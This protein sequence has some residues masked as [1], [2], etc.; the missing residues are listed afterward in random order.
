ML[1][2]AGDPVGRYRVVGS[3][4]ANQT[5]YAGMVTVERT[6]ETFRV[7]WRIGKQVF[8]GTGI[9]GDNGF[10]VAYRSGNRTGIAIYV[11][12]GVD[13]KGLWTYAGGRAIGAEA[14]IRR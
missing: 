8:V 11:A 4:P 6:G 5:K 7:T 2:W 13:W 14:W 3:N 10:A 9:G 12:K 1:A